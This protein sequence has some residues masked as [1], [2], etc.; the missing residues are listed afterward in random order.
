MSKRNSRRNRK[1]NNN[2]SVNNN[3]LYTQADYDKDAYDFNKSLTENNINKKAFQRL[4]CAD[5][6]R[7]S[8]LIE[9]GKIGDYTLEEIEIAMK[10]KHTGW[11]ILLEVSESLMRI[12]PH[13]YRLNNFYSNMAVFNWGIDLYDVKPTAK[14]ETINKVFDTLSS[15]LEKMQLKHEFGKIMKTLPYKDIFCGL[16]VEDSISFY[17]QEIHHKHYVLYEIADGLYSF[18]INLSTINPIQ[19]DAYPDYVRKAYIDYTEN[20]C[21]MYF[22]PP[23]DKQI[24]IKLNSQWVHPYPLLINLVDDILNLDTYKKLKLQSARTDN[25]KAIMIKVPI[26]ED[27]VDKPLLT[28]ATLATFAEL[29]R[30]SM[31]DDIG[32]LHTLGS[33]GT[34]VSFKDSNNITNYVEDALDDIYNASGISKELF[35]GSSSGTAVTFSIEN[36]SAIIYRVYDQFER[37]VN[38]WIKVNK[39]NKSNFKFSFYLLQ[40]T[41]F[42]KKDTRDMFKDACTQ[43]LTTL[44]RWYVSMGMTP[45]KIKGSY[46][47]HKDIYNFEEHL[48]QLSSS[49][50]SSN[51]SGSSSSSDG[52]RPKNADKGE[53]LDKS[54]QQTEDN[55]SNSKR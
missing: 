30:E 39:I 43:G 52:G 34:V 17:I 46:I 32:I 21:G 29:N 26:D 25:Y 50:N 20:K 53:P 55:D 47:L 36:D 12:S 11:R 37:W 1:R 28:P 8:R 18:A 31:T 23:Y 44:D 2:Q 4:L 22:V 7:K 13:Y 3:T 42:N 27:T 24:C 33:D 41:I 6:I 16:V 19:L 51:T 15:R 49:Y 54:G 45:S 9:N 5:L 14:S 40:M 10:S 35:N 38:R 48:I